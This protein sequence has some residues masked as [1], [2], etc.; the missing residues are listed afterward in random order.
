MPGRPCAAGAGGEGGGAGGAAG[1]A[2]G[3]QVAARVSRST[4]DSE[5][6]TDAASQAGVVGTCLRGTE[7]VQP[8]SCHAA[9]LTGEAGPPAAGLPVLESACCREEVQAEVAEPGSKADGCALDSVD[10]ERVRTAPLEQV[11]MGLRCSGRFAAISYIF[12]QHKFDLAYV[13]LLGRLAILLMTKF[14]CRLQTPSSAVACTTRL[15]VAS[16]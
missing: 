6:N 8:V 3:A 7:P 13:W 16:R 12:L 2:G 14:D 10:W 15:P 9:P 5:G 1:S 11:G 4:S